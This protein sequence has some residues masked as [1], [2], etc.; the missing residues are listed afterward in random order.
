[1]PLGKSKTEEASPQVL[2]AYKT[3]DKKVRPI[4]GVFPEEAR[5]TRQFP[6]DPLLS[7]PTVPTHPPEFVPS[8]RLTWECLATINVNPDDFL[9]PEE[10][11]LFHHILKLNDRTLAF[12]EEERGT[13]REDY[14]SPYIIP[15]EPHVPWAE[16][17]IPIHP[18]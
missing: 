15:V 4:P 12:S 3:V 17:N 5:V 6:E 18:V 13:L 11:K 9:W 1:M 16:R 10:V 7:L 2:G 8:S 14:F